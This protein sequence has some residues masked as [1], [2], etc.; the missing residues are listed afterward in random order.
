MYI[1]YIFGLSAVNSFLVVCFIDNNAIH[2]S[3]M[4]A[5]K[6]LKY[7]FKLILILDFVYIFQNIN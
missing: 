7:L 2:F 1:L 5:L 6:I 3:T 4:Y